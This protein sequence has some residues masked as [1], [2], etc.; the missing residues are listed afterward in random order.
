[1]K[2]KTLIL[3][4]TGIVLGGCSSMD[5]DEFKQSRPEFVLEDYFQGRTVAWGLFEDRFGNVQRQFVVEIDGTWDGET[6]VLNEDFVYNDG[7]T[8]NRVWSIVKTGDNTYEGETENAIG[9]AMG[10]RQGNAFH[11]T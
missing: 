3:M 11:W 4:L 8:E 9:K 6:L 2:A 5:I 10:V 1:M 7:E